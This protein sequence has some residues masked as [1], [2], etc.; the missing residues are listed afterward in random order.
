MGLIAAPLLSRWTTKRS[1][2]ATEVHGGKRVECWAGVSCL[3]SPIRVAMARRPPCQNAT[4]QHPFAPASALDPRDPSTCWRRVSDTRLSN[5]QTVHLAEV[6][7]GFAGWYRE[8]RQGPPMPSIVNRLPDPPRDRRRRVA[9]RDRDRPF[10]A[11]RPRNENPDAALERVRGDP[12]SERLTEALSGGGNGR[13]DTLRR[14]EEIPLQSN[15]VKGIAF[16]SPPPRNTARASWPPAG[17]TLAHVM[18]FR[19]RAPGRMAR[20]LKLSRCGE[21]GDRSN[22]ARA[23]GLAW[24]WLLRVCA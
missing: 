24:P 8:T 13:R 7:L 21:F 12:G 16:D 2:A 20:R 11:L 17:V 4:R 10:E 5:A 14:A 3:G 9:E 6:C 18:P 1:T 15:T 23:R 22:G 19:P